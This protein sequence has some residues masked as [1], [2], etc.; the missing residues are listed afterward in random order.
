MK[1][2]SAPKVSVIIPVF[3]AER[4]LQ[5]ALDSVSQQTYVNIE[6]IA[7]NDGSTDNSLKILV[8]HKEVDSRLIVI[9]RENRG[10]GATL[11]ELISAA[12]SDFI[13]R[14]DADDICTPERI[15]SQVNYM[16]K[17]PEHVIIGGQIKFLIGSSLTSASPMPQSHQAIRKQLLSGRFPLCHPAVFFRKS[18]GEQVGCYKV[19]GAGEDLD[20]FLRISEVGLA[21]N[22]PDFVLSYRITSNSLSTSKA[23]ELRMKY[24]WA[25]FN[26]KQRSQSN[27][28][29]TLP[30]FEERWNQ[31]SLG[32]KIID[33]SHIISE[34]YYRRSIA[35][36]VR[37]GTLFIWPFYLAAAAALRPRT[38]IYKA[39]GYLRSQ[40]K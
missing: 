34:I 8:A 6:I 23:T 35:L 21:G 15:E 9:S 17:Y 28:E 32:S 27:N 20:F 30:E 14:M 25:I 40:L 19:L 29:A 33:Q 5:E 16:L 10:L 37:K 18:A 11:N 3:N 1:S 36:K 26:A 31:R 4:Y 39:I 12:K 38:T 2:F 24:A 22:V 7:L 13:A